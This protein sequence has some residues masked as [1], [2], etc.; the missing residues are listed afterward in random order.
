MTAPPSDPPALRNDCFALP[1]GVDWMAADRA[2]DLLRDRC[3]TVTGAETVPLAEAAGR[4]L[5][6]PVAAARPNPPVANSAVDGYAFAAASLTGADP[7]RL[8]LIP[9]RA[10]AGAP[11]AAAV[12]PGEALRI[13]TGAALPAGTDTVVLQEDIGLEG[14]ELRLRPGLKPRANTRAVGEDFRTGAHLLPG[15]RLLRPQ[16]LALL[17][18]GGWAEV[19]ARRR[20]RVGVLSTGDELADPPGPPGATVDANRPMLLALLR[21][22]GMEAI[23]LGRAPDEPAQV[24][25]ALSR[26]AAEADAI[27]TSGGASAGDEDHVS[28]ALRDAGALTAWRIAVKPGRPLALATWRGAAVFGLPGNP[29]AAFVCALIFARPALL[30]LSGADWSTPQGF[31]VPAGFA[32]RRKTGRREFLRARIGPDGRAEPF[33]SEGSGLISGLSWST[34]LIDLPD[35][36]PDVAP[37]DPVRFLPYAS[38]GL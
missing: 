6:G 31:D 27:L 8:R 36:G 2:L 23:D 14:E 19:A 33:R 38:F 16:D 9:G 28:A 34:G 17:A 21:A 22:W 30:A 24:R 25:A 12:G 3:A 26:G 37:G 1:P 11:F 13:L 15:G 5:A 32:K 20:L 7:E 18:A 35:P 4:V 29:V 10:A